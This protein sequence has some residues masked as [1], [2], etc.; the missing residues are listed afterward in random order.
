MWKFY[1]VSEP[2]AY[3][4][5]LF[6]RV[7]FLLLLRPGKRE[8][9][10]ARYQSS[11]DLLKLDIQN[12]KE[13]YTKTK[14][15]YTRASQNV[16]IISQEQLSQLLQDYKNADKDLKTTNSKLKGIENNKRFIESKIIRLNTIVPNAK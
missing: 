8:N 2:R 11:Y 7:I 13:V 3:E 12:K 10:H 4:Q 15:A 9:L 16:D 1:S 5:I 14:D 6:C